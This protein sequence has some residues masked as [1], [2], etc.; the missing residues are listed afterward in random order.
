MELEP[1]L[2]IFLHEK[3][4]DL[5]YGLDQRIVKPPVLEASSAA[6]KLLSLDPSNEENI[7]SPA[8]VNVGFGAQT[9][10]EKFP[11]INQKEVH[12]FRKA[13]CNVIKTSNFENI[14]H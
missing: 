9:L 1:P 4:K 13:T 8:F 11:S 14:L 6:V 5:L 2:S 3:V 7:I 12:G 10:I